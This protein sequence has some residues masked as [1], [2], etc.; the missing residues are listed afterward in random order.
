M[1]LFCA[2]EIFFWGK[3]G[4]NVMGAKIKLF[5]FLFFSFSERLPSDLEIVL[6]KLGLG[7]LSFH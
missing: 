1:N 7:S 5:G 2:L 3:D 4:K 6:I